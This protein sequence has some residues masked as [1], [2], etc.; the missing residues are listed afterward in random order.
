MI[1][2]IAKLTK[3]QRRRAYFSNIPI[4]TFFIITEKHESMPAYDLTGYF[5]NIK[6]QILKD[7]TPYFFG[8]I[9]KGSWELVGNLTDNIGIL[10][11]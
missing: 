5:L 6:P 3:E 8:Y 7:G 2:Q 4:G 9:E 11:R 1:G 10:K